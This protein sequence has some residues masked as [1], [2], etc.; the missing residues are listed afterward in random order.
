MY[1]G[2]NIYLWTKDLSRS[3]ILI[4]KHSVDT[5]NAWIK[6]INN[7]NPFWRIIFSDTKTESKKK[8]ILK[9]LIFFYLL[10]T[11]NANLLRNIK[12]SLLKPIQ[13]HIHW[14]TFFRFW[15]L[16]C[17]MNNLIYSEINTLSWTFWNC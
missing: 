1:F 2:T 11:R 15:I 13:I 4:L 10:V 16:N 6:K 17:K 3:Y 8:Q 14:S 7:L 5:E 12:I 9:S